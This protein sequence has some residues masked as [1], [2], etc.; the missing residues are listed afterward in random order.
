M[1]S[2]S[3]LENPPWKGAFRLKRMGSL[4]SC[5]APNADNKEVPVG[6]F[7]LSAFQRGKVWHT[8]RQERKGSS[9][10][11]DASVSA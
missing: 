2:A 7:Q 11:M 5:S 10:K 3:F 4:S 1:G 9:F 6:A 8:C